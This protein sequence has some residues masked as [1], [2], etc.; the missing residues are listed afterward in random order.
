[1]AV[2]FFHLALLVLRLEAEPA[3]GFQWLDCHGSHFNPAWSSLR[4]LLSEQKRQN[5]ELRLERPLHPKFLDLLGELEPLC[6]GRREVVELIKWT[7]VGDAALA[8]AT[9][10]SLGSMRWWTEASFEPPDGDDGEAFCL[11]GCAT[12]FYLFAFNQL[13]ILMSSPQEPTAA[14]AKTAM[15]YVLGLLQYSRSLFGQDSALDF[16]GSSSWPEIG[17]ATSQLLQRAE[18][19]VRGTPPE[20][21]L[22]ESDSASS[23]SQPSVLEIARIWHPCDPLRHEGCFAQSSKVPH[24]WRRS[25]GHGEQLALLLLGEHAPFANNVWQCVE[26]AAV[27]LGASIRAI[28]AG[29]F[30]GCKGLPSGCQADAVTSW[31]RSW[32]TRWPT[33]GDAAL[34]LDDLHD[35]ADGLMQ[36][37][38]AHPDRQA[39]SPD[40]LL[41]GDSALFCWLLRRRSALGRNAGLHLLP[42]LHIYSMVFLQYVP[43]GWQKEMMQD[44]SRWWLQERD[45][46]REPAGVNMEALGMQLQYQMGIAVPYVPSF[47]TAEAAG[48]LYTAP[49]PGEGRSVLVMK[50]GFFSRAPGRVFDTV[51]RRL[52]REAAP[53]HISWNHWASEKGDHAAQFLDFEAMAAHS[54][55]LYVAPEF[56]QLMLRDLYGAGVP[57]LHPDQR[58]HQR[59]LQHMFA[60]WGQLHTEHDIGRVPVTEGSG[61]RA[62]QEE[63][64][65]RVAAAAGSWPYPPF[66]EP[67]QHPP[68]HLAYWLPLAE[69]HRFPHVLKFS[70]LIELLEMVRETDMG[71][72]SLKMQEQSRRVAANVRRFYRESVRQLLAAV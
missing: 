18:G 21:A 46:H 7:T 65:R 66:Y 42:A 36:A 61:D 24:A 14:E 68:E 26:S 70:S 2:T 60:S 12:V 33:D 62:E 11:Y 15:E 28:F 44:Y 56:V 1:M 57:I 63:R 13:S 45:E 31:F 3:G 48:V 69:V 27:A 47:G 9:D 41:C 58:W 43:V 38:M 6:K 30:Y 71:A 54:C 37:L 25:N 59:L 35:E 23:A 53:G 29:A 64:A 17:D 67:K 4:E 34:S 8:Q 20:E 5:L 50:S 10:T 40:L 32:M 49:G 52:A 55:A 16:M 19:L 72:Q 39:A 22:P 51:L